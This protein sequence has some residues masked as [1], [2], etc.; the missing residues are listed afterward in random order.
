M[1]LHHVG[2]VSGLLLC[3]NDLA[4][5]DGVTFRDVQFWDEED[6]ISARSRCIT[7][8]EAS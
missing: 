7:L 4:I 2:S 8:G 1:C 6:D 5:G 3:Y